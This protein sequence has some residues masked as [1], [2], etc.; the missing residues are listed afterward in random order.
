MKNLFSAF[1]GLIL[2]LVVLQSCAPDA[3]AAFVSENP[4][5]TESASQAGARDEEG[6]AGPEDRTKPAATDISSD[7]HPLSI[8]GLRSRAFE[9]EDFTLLDPIPAEAGLSARE[10][11]YRSG[12]LLVYGLIEQPAGPAPDGGWPVIVLAHGYIPPENYTTAGNYRLVTRYYASGGF[13]VV[14]PDYRS[15]GRS[16]GPDADDNFTRTIDYSIDVMNLIAG[17]SEIPDADTG[18]VFLYGHSMGGEIGLRI[19]TVNNSL[20]GASLWAGVTEDYPENTLYFL[21]KRAP[22]L[23]EQMKVKVESAFTP[24]EISTMSPNRYFGDIKAPILIHHGTADESVPFEW[25]IP[26]RERLDEAGT[27]YRFYEYPGE[28][29]N[30]SASFY[31][32]MDRDME[33]FRTLMD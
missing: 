12:G 24:E 21:R 26:F 29:H 13:M 5:I 23:A 32:V 31:R 4:G 33:F 25:S 7:P 8:P 14:K 3:E 6:A 18:N 22:E 15:H 1:T 10:F 20:K 2:L 19:L 28:D 11:S 17:L 30:I 27:D 16:E 9:A